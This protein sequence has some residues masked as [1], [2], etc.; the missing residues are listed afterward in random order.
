MNGG[1]REREVSPETPR[2]K[3]EFPYFPINNLHASCLC[4]KGIDFLMHWFSLEIY[5]HKRVSMCIILK[6]AIKRYLELP[7]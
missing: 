6:H 3:L 7:F 4:S 5:L 1:E 2:P